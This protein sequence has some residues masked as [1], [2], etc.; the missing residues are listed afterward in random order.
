MSNL[1]FVTRSQN[2]Q[3]SCSCNVLRKTSAAK[4]SKPIIGRE[5]GTEK[6]TTFVSIKD[7][8]RTLGIHAGSIQKCCSGQTYHAGN[9]E[10]EY[11]P[12][13]DSDCLPDEIWS[14]AL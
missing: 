4:L 7:A 12:N 6:W 2:V 5:R 3:H 8:E 10:F 1:E 14:T 11:L 13:D 9:Y